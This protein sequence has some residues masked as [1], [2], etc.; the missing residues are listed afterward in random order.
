V[1]QHFSLTWHALRS[2]SSESIPE[3]GGLH[4]ADRLSFLAGPGFM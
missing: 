1:K 4:V 2:E 3:M